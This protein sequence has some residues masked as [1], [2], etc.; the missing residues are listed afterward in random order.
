MKRIIRKR[1]VLVLLLSLCLSLTACGNGNSGDSGNDTGVTPTRIEGML[2]EAYDNTDY[3]SYLGLWDGVVNEGE[4]EQKLIAELNEDGEPRFELYVDGNLVYYGFLQIRPQY[5]NYVYA[6]NEYDSCGKIMDWVEGHGLEDDT[7]IIFASDN[8]MNLGQHGIWGKGNGT[9]PPNMYDSSVKVP[10]I[11]KVPGCEAPGSTCSAM[12]GQYDIFPTILSL[13]G[14]EYK[15]EPKQPGKS[16]MEQINHPTAEYEDRIVVFD[17]YSKT[18]MI[19]KGKLKYIHRYGDGPCEFYDLSTDPDEENNLYGNPVW[20]EQIQRL[21]SEMEEWFDRY[22]DPKMDARKGGA[23]GRGQEKMC[24]EENA[25]DQ[26]IELYYKD[27]EKCR[28]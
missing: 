4:P 10:F 22:T 25:F 18:R 15:L 23:V 20:E 24:Y 19:K 17:E 26:S 12:A 9:Y 11:I 28:V 1:V 14:C 21:K 16:L 6:C 7:V 5:E 2:K 8:G 27:K 3:T 13:A